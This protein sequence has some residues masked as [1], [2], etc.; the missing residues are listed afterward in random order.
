MNTLLGCVTAARSLTLFALVCGRMPTACGVMSTPGGHA[1]HGVSYV[2]D[3]EIVLHVSPFAPTAA[4]LSWVCTNCNTSADSQS[5]FEVWRSFGNEKPGEWEV[6]GWTVKMNWQSV[7]ML[8]GGR[9][10]H[11]VCIAYTKQCSQIVN[12]TNA[13]WKPYRGKVVT[14]ATKEFPRIGEGTLVRWKSQLLLFLSRQSQN[15]DVGA[16]NITLLRSTDGGDTWSEPVVIPPGNALPSRANPGAVVLPN[17]LIVLSYFVG[18]NHQNATR[19]VRTSSDG[20][21]T[22]TTEKTLTDGSYPYMTGAHDRM[23]MLSNGRLIQVVHAR[24]ANTH[25]LGTFVF[26]S[27]DSGGTWKARGLANES[28][29]Y[30]PLEDALL[31]H[32][33]ITEASCNEFGFWEAAAVETSPKAGDGHMLLVGRTCTGW[34]YQSLSYDFGTTWSVPVPVGGPESVREGGIR[35]PLAPPNI[36]QVT[37]R[38]TEA[39]VLVTEPHFVPGQSLLG[40]RCVLGLQLSW[41][42]GET[43]N[44]YIEIEAVG[45][46]DQLSYCL[47]FC[48]SDM[49][50]MIYR[51]QGGPGMILPRYQRLNISSLSTKSPQITLSIE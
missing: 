9:Y 41:D 3:V 37:I 16:S 34:L 50:H 32:S 33:L 6:L 12:T 15:A 4:D 27:D 20:G 25:G 13:A 29:L 49:L 1:K 26:T 30:I 17:G 45:A 5:R 39:L 36:L 28:Y 42:R 23:R 43:W 19:V 2:D 18:L 21:I 51:A 14:E 48:D 31:P 38:D 44:G 24:G 35:H 10:G 8:G 47:L 40:N 22:W 7:G 11:K 46:E